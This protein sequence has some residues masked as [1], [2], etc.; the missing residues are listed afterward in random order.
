MGKE[1]ARNRSDFLRLNNITKAK[2]LAVI[3]RV[4][5]KAFLQFLFLR[6]IGEILRPH[7]SKPDT[8]NY[9]LI[10]KANKE[11]VSSSGETKKYDYSETIADVISS[12]KQ[13]IFNNET[14]KSLPKPFFVQHLKQ[15]FNASSK[16]QLNFY[17]SCQK[18]I[19]KDD[20][21]HYMHV[22]P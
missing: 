21:L 15:A 7:H 22:W 19:V 12:S 2:Q 20:K 11:L 1:R 9:R 8:Q 3:F 16:Y 10:K 5:I 13:V 18:F 17:I 4:I 14:P 6:I